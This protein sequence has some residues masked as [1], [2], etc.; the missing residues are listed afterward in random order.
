MTPTP[1]VTPTPNAGLDPDIFESLIMRTSTLLLLASLALSGCASVPEYKI[2]REGDIALEVE[3]VD[4]EGKPILA[5]EV[6]RVV[7]PRLRK[8]LFADS[9]PP[10]ISF[11]YLDRVTQR[12]KH[13]PEFAGP[14]RPNFFEALE[15]SISTGEA[16]NRVG[17][18]DHRGHAREVMKFDG[19]RPDIVQIKVSALHYGYIPGQVKLLVKKGEAPPTQR[20]VLQR[21]PNIH[22]P[23]TQYLKDFSRIR[24]NSYGDS[25]DYKDNPETYRNE[26]I[27]AAQTAE[28]AGDFKSA[29]RIYSWVPYVPTINNFDHSSSNTS[30][31][32]FGREDERSD[33]NVAILDKAY[34]LDPENR[35]IRMKIN[36]LRPPKDRAKRIAMLE[37]LIKDDKD[38]LWPVVFHIL[39]KEYFTNGNRDKAY[40][41]LRWYKDFEP[42]DRFNQT[43]LYKMSLAK[44]VSLQEFQ[45]DFLIAGDPNR[46]D[47]YGKLP[48]YYAVIAGRVDL[49]DWLL[50]NGVATPL[51]SHL[52]VQAVLSSNPQMVHRL[53]KTAP[54]IT[55]INSTKSFF[56][57]SKLI[58]DFRKSPSSNQGDLDEI[59]SSIK[60]FQNQKN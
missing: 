23:T 59:E 10:D 47:K 18:T 19:S 27:T 34:A 60:A 48:I 45:Q 20:I 41:L 55:G 53:L 24:Y 50:G 13:I 31:T 1:N 38:S 58:N 2:V 30:V 4:A 17:P 33:R 3:V 26:L 39:K 29:A 28:A 21:D 11:D 43:D 51:P 22:V 56:V 25:P 8:P 15:D 9:A 54:S 32:G 12:Y 42:E 6:W 7:N 46:K 49:Y 36:L 16:F 14:S 40:S 44:F 5:A 35:Y 57:E 52:T 37:N